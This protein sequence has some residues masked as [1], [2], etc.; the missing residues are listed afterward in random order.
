MVIDS[1]G[2]CV[3]RIQ[4]VKYDKYKTL[5]EEENFISRK[6]WIRKMV[7]IRRKYLHRVW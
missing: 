1:E 7:S 6:K 4:N 5:H 3:C 2:Y